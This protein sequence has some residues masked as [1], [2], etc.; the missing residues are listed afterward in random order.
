MPQVQMSLEEKLKIGVQAVELRKQGKH[1]EADAMM[2]RIPV[3]PYLA[4][5]AKET[6]GPDFLRQGGWDLSE[7]NEEYGPDWLG[8]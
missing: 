7:A 8:N 1:D 6:F 4:K 5:A 3:T 2:K